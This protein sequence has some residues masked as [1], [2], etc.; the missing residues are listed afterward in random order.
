M[1]DYLDH[2]IQLMTVTEGLIMKHQDFQLSFS[3]GFEKTQMEM[4]MVLFEKY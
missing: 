2:V 4:A 1:N 3:T